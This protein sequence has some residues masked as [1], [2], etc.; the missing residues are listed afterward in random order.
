[1]NE[2][3][4]ATHPNISRA[5]KHGYGKFDFEKRPPYTLLTDVS[6]INTKDERGPIRSAHTR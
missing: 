5:E 2:M 6:I 4:C 3:P 1:M